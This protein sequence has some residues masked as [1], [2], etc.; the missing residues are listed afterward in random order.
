MALGPLVKLL[1]EGLL[2]VPQVKPFL[3]ILF[4]QAQLLV[5]L[6]CSQLMGMAIL[7]MMGL[8]GS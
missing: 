5:I 3:E 7:S 6:A 2:L 8:C 4:G 1:E